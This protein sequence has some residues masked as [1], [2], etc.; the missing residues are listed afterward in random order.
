MAS[1]MARLLTVPVAGYLAQR[2]GVPWGYPLVFALAGVTGLASTFSYSRVPD[3]APS[4]AQTEHLRQRTQ[5]N[6]SLLFHDRRFVLFCLINFVWNLGVQISSPY[7]SVYM[8]QDLGFQVDTVAILATVATV[9]SIIGSRL[10]GEVVDRWGAVRAT[11]FSMLLVP[12]M[13]LLWTLMRTPWQV[14]IA[15]CYSEL[16]WSCF[17][18]AATPLILLLTPPEQRARYIA[19]FNF[20]NGIATVLGP[21]PA[22][23]IY[24][25]LG[26]KTV[27]YISAA[28]RGLGGLGFLALAIWGGLAKLDIVPRRQRA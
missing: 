28:G 9:C 7:F 13:P 6:W 1:Y 12:F 2:L 26:F 11:A 4:E 14:S 22:G 25:R 15:Q 23:V 10:A 27:L 16:S 3:I 18:V 5:L 17:R 21:L 19:I 8:V 20:I 24:A